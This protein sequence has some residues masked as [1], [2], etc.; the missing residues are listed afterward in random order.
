MIRGL[1]LLSLLFCVTFAAKRDCP[2]NEE[3]MECGTPCEPKCNQPMPDICTMNCIVDFSDREDVPC[4]MIFN[5]G[6]R[7]SAGIQGTTSK[8]KI[9]SR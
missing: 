8:N 3:W 5:V 7:Y 1:V 9:S 4:S 2:A 6:E